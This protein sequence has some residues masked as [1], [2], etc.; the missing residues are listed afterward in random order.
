VVRAGP[1]LTTL[2]IFIMLALYGLIE[3]LVVIVPVLVS[4]AFMTVVERKILAAMQR[5]VGPNAV[6]AYGMLQPFADALKLVVKEVVLPSQATTGVF[7]LAPALT[8]VFSLLGWAVIP[9]GSG[10]A[11]ADLE[12][13]LL[14]TLAVSSIG[15]YGILLAGWSAN[16]KY[17]FL[18]SLRSSAQMVSYELI[19]SSAILPVVI[20]AG[21][22]SLTVMVE[23]QQAIWYIVPLCPVFV[24]YVISVLAETNRTPFDLPEAESELVAGFF[25]EHSG[26]PFVLF[27]LGEYCSL[28][29]I[30]A[31]TA[32]LFLGGYGMPELFVNTTMISLEAAVLALKSCL[33]AFAFVW[34]RATL[35]RMR[36]DSLMTFCWTGCLPLA[37]AFVLLV[38]S[39][40][41]AFDATT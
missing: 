11:L 29:L 36:W 2:Y 23:A 38:P 35:P 7:L 31:L 28:V 15:V 14:Y 4:V 37:I 12:L 20:L 27:F 33:G 16:S 22:F 6:G 30:S 5:R 25:T 34:F 41:V 3:V 40:L 32:T 17:A 18:G 8:L 10:L 26:M 19:L 1:L 21:S 24:L 13:G 9:F 39:I